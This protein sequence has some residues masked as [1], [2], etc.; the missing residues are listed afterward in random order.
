MIIYL[1]ADSKN[2]QIQK[3]WTSADFGSVAWRQSEITTL[4]VPEHEVIHEY[5]VVNIIVYTVHTEFVDILCRWKYY[6]AKYTLLFTIH[7]ITIKWKISDFRNIT[8]SLVP[9]N[10]KVK[11]KQIPYINKMQAKWCVCFY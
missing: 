11:C 8:Y 10:N 5:C 4:C 7:V 3:F 6:T 2:D 9:L 1:R